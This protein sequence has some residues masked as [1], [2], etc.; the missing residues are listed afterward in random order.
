MGTA[1]VQTYV[2]YISKAEAALWQ[3]N[4]MI[5][6]VTTGGR[7]VAGYLCFTALVADTVTRLKSIAQTVTDGPGTVQWTGQR[8]H[9]HCSVTGMLLSIA[10]TRS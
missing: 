4:Y 9:H 3:Q 1:R 6:V 7:A 2:R 8:S 5:L 10:A